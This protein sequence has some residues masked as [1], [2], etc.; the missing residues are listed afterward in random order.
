METILE[1]LEVV[2][3]DN[4][5]SRLPEKFY[6]H[7]KPTPVKTPN[8]IKLNES[9]ANHLRMNLKSIDCHKYFSGNVLLYCNVLL[10]NIHG[11][12]GLERRSNN[13]MLLWGLH[14]QF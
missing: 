3:F 2:K 14:G 8:L 12:F 7:V 1:N 11:L 5:F 9:L 10:L 6:A 13:R 4:S